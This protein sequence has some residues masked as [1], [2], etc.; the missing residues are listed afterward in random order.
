MDL[1][2]IKKGNI[3]LA[4]LGNRKDSDIGKILPI[5]VFQ[6]NL[7]NM[8]IDRSEFRDV[9]IIPLSSKI[10]ENQFT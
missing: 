6:N 7:L 8:M 10:R 9:V 4:N 2:S 3:Y 1:M 5:L